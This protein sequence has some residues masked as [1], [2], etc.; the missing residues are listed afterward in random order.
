MADHGPQS[1]RG[2]F[3]NGPWQGPNVMFIELLI[4]NEFIHHTEIICIAPNAINIFIILKTAEFV[5][6][7]LSSKHRKI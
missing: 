4:T 5:V 3:L 2:Y 6:F 7:A 1:G